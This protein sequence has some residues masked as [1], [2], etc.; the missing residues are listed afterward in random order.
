MYK[1]AG[2]KMGWNMDELRQLG[3]ATRAVVKPVLDDLREEANKLVYQG[4]DFN[5]LFSLS[6]PSFFSLSL[7][8]DRAARFW[9]I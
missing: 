3:K 7:F 1:I 5:I 6:S 8:L 9:T 2:L 4:I